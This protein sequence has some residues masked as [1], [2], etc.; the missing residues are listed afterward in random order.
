MESSHPDFHAQSFLP[1]A[2]QAAEVAIDNKGKEKISLTVIEPGE[3]F[4]E[5]SILTG[6]P[7]PAIFKP[8]LLYSLLQIFV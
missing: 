1:L 8:Q 5:M 7:T 2:Y 6:E 4:G 3:Y